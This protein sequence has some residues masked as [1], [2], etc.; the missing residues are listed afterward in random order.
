MAAYRRAEELLPRDAPAALRAQVLL[1]LAWNEAI[2]ADPE[3]SRA[4]LA[5]SPR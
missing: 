5:E 2:L 3:R 1:G 4:L